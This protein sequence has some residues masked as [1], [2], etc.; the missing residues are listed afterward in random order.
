MGF[1]RA[2]LLGP[3]P[4]ETSLFSDMVGIGLN[5]AAQ[6][7][8]NADIEVTLA[9]A[10]CLGMDEGDLRVLSVLTTWIG[11]HADYIHADRLTRAVSELSSLR[12]SAYWSAIARGLE[13]D[14]RF[15]RLQDHYK[16]PPQDILPVG[17]EFQLLRRGEDE[18]FKGS[19]LRV[20]AGTLRDRKADVMSIQDLVARH[21]MYRNR[22]IMGP[23]WRADVW[24]ILEQDSSLSIAELA[25]RAGSSFAT[26][27]QVAR[28]FE[29]AST[30]SA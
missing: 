24:T 18:R 15:K 20:P 11:V 25:R 27:W 22:V 9:Y 14:R 8:L 5:F 6:P 4:D 7:N 10:S 12:A 28:D 2:K 26:A 23:S 3:K 1:S 30:P 29:L 16:G 21:K 19:S 17:T 13:Q